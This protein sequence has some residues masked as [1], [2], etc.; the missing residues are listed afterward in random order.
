MISKAALLMDE[1]LGFADHTD[2]LGIL[3]APALELAKS[4]SLNLD[5]QVDNIFDPTCGNPGFSF[6]GLGEASQFSEQTPN[7]G[8]NPQTDPRVCYLP[9]LSPPRYQDVPVMPGSDSS[10]NNG[11]C[12]HL[13]L[14]LPCAFSWA[15]YR[16]LHTRCLD[17]S[18][19]H[20]GCVHYGR[21]KSWPLNGR[22]GSSPESIMAAT[23][24]PPDF[25]SGAMT[26]QGRS[27]NST[28]T[29]S[30]AFYTAI[31][32]DDCPHPTICASPPPAKLLK[33]TRTTCS[34]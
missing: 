20:R 3:N 12:V 24:S 6:P 29:A 19:R 23:H 15:L 34:V 27:L 18:K 16:L 21:C 17:L 14:P 32:G 9:D 1:L 25:D 4:L 28:A 30:P 2:G 5:W 26:P 22:C 11:R 10:V 33:V 8:T 31:R 7:R 13:Q